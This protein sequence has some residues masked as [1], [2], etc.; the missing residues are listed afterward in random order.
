MQLISNKKSQ[1]WWL[2]WRRRWRESSGHLWLVT[3]SDR[4]LAPPVTASETWLLA[5]SCRAR[6]SR[7]SEELS[8]TETQVSSPFPAYWWR[9]ATT[10]DEKILWKRQK[11]CT[12]THHHKCANWYTFETIQ[13]F[14]IS[15]TGEPKKLKVFYCWLTIKQSELLRTSMSYCGLGFL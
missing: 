11:E 13:V 10:L 1:Q 5:A 8:A 14:K 15:K 2:W 12:T 7:A 3:G 4:W 9:P 6:T